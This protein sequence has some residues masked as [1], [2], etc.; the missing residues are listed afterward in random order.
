MSLSVGTRL[1]TENQSFDIQ[2]SVA[3]ILKRSLEYFEMDARRT[4]RGSRELPGGN[5]RPT[6]KSNAAAAQKK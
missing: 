3:V 5:D 2:P 4:Q 6:N 1:C